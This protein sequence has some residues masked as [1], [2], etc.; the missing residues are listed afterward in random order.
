[1]EIVWVLILTIRAVGQ[2]GM[3]I[4]AVD[5]FKSRESCLVAANAWLKQM[6]EMQNAR[7]TPRAL[8]V[9]K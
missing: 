4:A 7:G 2:H 9:R 6:N 1:M 5:G 8:C 3:S